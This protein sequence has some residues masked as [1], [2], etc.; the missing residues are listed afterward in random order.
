MV[1]HWV[2]IMLAEQYLGSMV[3]FM[4]TFRDYT[5]A[6]QQLFGYLDPAER[7]PAK[8]PAH[9]VDELVEKLDLSALYNRYSDLGSPG[10][11][12]RLHLKVF[13]LGYMEGVFSSRRLMHHCERDIAF[14]FLT[15]DQVPNFRTI[16]RFRQLHSDDIRGVFQQ[17]LTVAR[18]M[19]LVRIG[20]LVIDSTTIKANAA[21]KAT[22]T[23]DKLD[24][25]L[26][27]LDDYIKQLGS[28]D[29]SEEELAGDEEGNLP[30]ELADSKERQR[31]IAGA[32]QR[33]HELQALKAKAGALSQTK[34]SA[35]DP[36][37][38]FRRDGITNQIL[39]AFG[40]QVATSEDGFIVEAQVRSES[41]DAGALEPVLQ[42]AQEN[43]RSDLKKRS[44]YADF[45]YYGGAAV[46]RLKAMEI[47]PMIPDQQ[48]IRRL[49][50]KEPKIPHP[51]F[52]HDAATDSFTCSQ[53]AKLAFAA[54]EE[55]RNRNRRSRRVYRSNT[56]T[57]QAC[58]MKDSCVGTKYPYKQIKITGEPGEIEQHQSQ[59]ET[60]ESIAEYRKF[61][62]SIEKIF[63]HFK[64]N[65]RMRQFFTRGLRRVS[66]EWGLTCTAY[67]IVRMWNAKAI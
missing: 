43:L 8:H 55:R 24:A 61:R 47:I 2:R 13:L 44:V 60:K 36:D 59:F 66:G 40:C 6:Q 53:G 25:E 35:T 63:G 37:C 48:T 22:T 18:T 57:C 27:Q 49:S 7:L 5:P 56:Q 11:D 33:Q 17:V 29:Q 39:P 26:A 28:N 62:R 4:P 46:Q 31:R 54:I 51:G 21:R 20:R 12:S 41:V 45:G 23:I 1:L 14:I 65:L 30:E 67:N 42:G 64:G 52:V 10:Y 3:H 38:V 19:G 16:A 9:F 58:P 50:G 34:I 15:R 32:L